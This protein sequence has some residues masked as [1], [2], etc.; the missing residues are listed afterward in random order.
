MAS[1]FVRSTLLTVTLACLALPASAGS[2]PVLSPNLAARL[3]TSSLTV[4]SRYDRFIVRYRDSAAVPA[5]AVEARVR[6]MT[7]AMPGGNAPLAVTHL[8]RLGAGGDVVRVSRKLDAAQARAFMQQLASD[9]AVAHVEPDIVMRAVRDVSAGHVVRAADAAGTPNDPLY[10]TNQWHFFDPVGG[11]NAAAAW[12]LTDG[13]GMVVAVIDTGITAHPDLD[14]S[15][16]DDGYDFISDSSQSGRPAD[17]RAAG[18]WDTGDWSTEEPWASE[19]LP[20]PS[21][22]H[23]THVAGTIAELTD[24]GVG[25]AGLAR[26]ARILPVRVLGHCGGFDSDI[27][28]A[29]EW[30]SGGHVDGV[31]DNTHPA[32]VINMSLGGGG[33]CDADGVMATAIGHAISRG[34]TVVVAAGNFGS[35]AQYVSPA[36]C[37]GVITVAA[38]GITGK[39]AFY[40]DIGETVALAAPGGGIYLDD[41]PNTNEEVD[42]G[43]VWSTINAGT[44]TVSD[45]AYGGLAGTS[46]ATPHVAATVALVQA[47]RKNAGMA[48]LAP[49]T[50]RQLLIDTARPF[51]EPMPAQISIGSGILDAAAALTSAGVTGRALDA[52]ATALASNVPLTAQSVTSGSTR[53]YRIEAPYGAGSL[54]V[55]TLGGHGA[56]TMYVK[57]G[58]PPAVDGSDA[59]FSSVRAGT[60][61]MVVLSR[62]GAGIYYARLVATTDTTGLSVLGAVTAPPSH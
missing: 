21:S 33:E 52:D 38:T 13:T 40:S 31:P 20:E 41:D 11:V 45:P 47:G 44:T 51:P 10:A 12:D 32:Q 57:R 4:D 43:F 8:R 14:T 16:A 17:G 49:A 39:R 3:N 28:D 9:P 5:R 50:V 56:V 22:W 46:Q 6:G 48:A 54:S 25:M 59:D 7:A 37:P 61:Q 23:G 30:A 26:G 58:T 35:D 60:T 42:N 29:V 55:R 27:S 34:T 2:A 18:G 19:C 62:P 1:N 15:L 36:N 53:L 24:N